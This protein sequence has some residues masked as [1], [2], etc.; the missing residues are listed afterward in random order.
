MNSN[1]Q[2]NIHL[3]KL[4]DIHELD[5]SRNLYASLYSVTCQYLARTNSSM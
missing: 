2:F 1:Q 4:E 5:A 3:A